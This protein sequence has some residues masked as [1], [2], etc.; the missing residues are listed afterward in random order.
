MNI[1]ILAAGK[2]Q[3][4][5]DKGFKEPKPFIKIKGRSILDRQLEELAGKGSDTISVYTRKEY[6]D[7]PEF[8]HLKEKYNRV[9]WLFVGDTK[10][11]IETI[12]AGQP[13]GQHIFIDCDILF[14]YEDIE[15]GWKAGN[16]VL[17]FTDNWK[18]PKYSYI[19]ADNGIIKRVTEKSRTSNFASCGI[20][21][22]AHPEFNPDSSEGEQYQ[23]SEIN[24][25]ISEGE[26]F[27]MIKSTYYINLGTPEAVRQNY[28][29]IEGEEGPGEDVF[30]K[31]TVDARWFN[32]IEESEGTI[33]KSGPGV[34]AERRWY[35]NIDR[36]W[37]AKHCPKLLPSKKEGAICMEKVEGENV[38]LAYTEKGHAP[39]LE[40][41]ETLREL[42]LTTAG[43]QRVSVDM[44]HKFYVDKLVERY[45]SSS[46]PKSSIQI[47]R[48]LKSRV[49]EELKP[50]A[51]TPI[52][53]DPV[54]TNIIKSDRG[55]V[56][57]D[58]RGAI[59]KVNTTYGD[60]FYDY[61]KV[62]QS[63]AGYDF[64]LHGCRVYK[65]HIQAEKQQF[66]KLFT[67]EEAKKIKLLAAYLA[68]TL[69]PL[70]INKRE[71]LYEFAVQLFEES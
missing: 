46:Y 39:M 65:E 29:R 64:I 57:I 58:P 42:H 66:L 31:K 1:A 23:S 70:H 41:V 21:G 67:E 15:E 28:G 49:E 16:F 9:N 20:Y 17:S 55:L 38:S 4:F 50:I 11:A 8:E 47:Y 61:A 45:S 19:E 10:S 14:K 13:K 25:K 7:Y 26:V 43:P 36:A 40:I 37:S 33:H 69:V 30:T 24:R 32:S 51:L 44:V 52:H 56:F 54:F 22:Y 60:M 6:T 34:E 12:Q 18:I 53:G 62:Y 68:F 5:A 59:G 71:Q 3:R 2:G 48:Q 63:V 27:R 35:R